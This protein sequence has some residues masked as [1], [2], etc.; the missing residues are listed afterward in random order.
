MPFA[1]FICQYCILGVLIGGLLLLPACGPDLIF[2]TVKEV[3]DKG[4]AYGDTLNFTFEIGDTNRVYNLWLEVHHAVDYKT[5]N[6][7]TK[8]HTTFPDQQTLEEVVS[9]ELADK[10]GQWYG[11]CGSEGCILR[12]PLQSDAY[13][14]QPGQYKLAVE[15]YTRRDTLNGIHAL[16]FAVE[17]TGVSRL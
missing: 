15:Q 3:P 11:K 2:D 1:R 5:Q 17:D 16:R 9:L 7:Y 8:L 14:N 13:F 12:V 10:A 4:W 6:L